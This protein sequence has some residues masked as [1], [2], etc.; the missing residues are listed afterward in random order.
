MLLHD[1]ANVSHHQCVISLDRAMLAIKPYVIH[2]ATICA[3]IHVFHIKCCF[4]VS[5]FFQRV[6]N[7]LEFMQWTCV[8]NIHS[9]GGW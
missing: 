8:K 1:C 7:L 2:A 3:S 4:S 6:N 9:S 5:Y